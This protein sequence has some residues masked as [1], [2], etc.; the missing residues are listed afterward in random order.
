LYEKL[1]GCIVYRKVMKH[2]YLILIA[3]FIFGF[4]S[5]GI[6]FLYNNVGGVSDVDAVTTE[7]TLLDD[8]EKPGADTVKKGTKADVLPFTEITV[9]E[10]GGCAR[11]DGCASYHI[12]N[13]GAYIYMVRS[14]GE[15]EKRYEGMLSQAEQSVLAKTFA[16]V[17]IVTKMDSTFVG[18]CASATDG[19]AYRY[20][21]VERG[22]SY[23]LDSCV[24]KLSGIDFFDTLNSY[25]GVFNDIYTGS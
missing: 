10:Y 3:T 1:K 9:H 23:G 18:M 19:I 8:V 15:E 13:T 22:T 4:V 16:D 7:K 24:Q 11:T 20:D 6:L 5:G 12:S 2:T 14:R 17:D 25:F 21:L